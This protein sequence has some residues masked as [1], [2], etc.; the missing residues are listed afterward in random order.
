MYFIRAPYLLKY[1]SKRNITWNIRTSEKNIYLTFDDGP[2]PEITPWVIQ[3]L[4]QY[5]AKATFFC[6]GENVKKYPSIFNALILAG[7]TI[8]N[9]SYNHLSGWKY[10]SKNY[11]ENIA[12]CNKQ[13]DSGLF[14]PPYGKI[15][16]TQILRLRY[17][18]FTIV[19]WSVLSG[20][21]DQQITPEKCL[22]NVIENTR[23]GSIVVFHDNIKAKENLYFT[24]PKF[25]EYFANK[26]YTFKALTKEVC[27]IKGIS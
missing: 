17:R 26:G 1:F 5:R 15:T 19:L 11:L 21:F 2:I 9:H 13:L 16:P 7:H 12:K 20:D 6:V 3:L 18:K 8:G 22:Q 10:L 24:L 4:E 14:R 27:A 23:K 25:L